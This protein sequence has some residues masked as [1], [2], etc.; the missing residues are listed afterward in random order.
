MRAASD[1][2]SSFET[3]ASSSASR[4]ASAGR[5]DVRDRQREVEEDVAV[6]VRE[7]AGL[8]HE[9]VAVQQ[10]ERRVAEAL[11]Q[12]LEQPGS[13]AREGEVGVA[14]AGVDLHRQRIAGRLVRL[15]RREQR[16]SAR[17]RTRRVQPAAVGGDRLQRDEASLARASRPSS[18]TRLRPRATRSIRS[19]GRAAQ[20]ASSPSSCQLVPRPAAG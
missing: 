3:G 9:R 8:A 16:P 1:A 14:E 17:R 5:D 20:P 13:R 2:Y 7:P 6:D 18:A 10:H 19:T 15:E 12:R 4:S 11:D